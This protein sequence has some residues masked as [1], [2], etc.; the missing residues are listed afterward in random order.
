MDKSQ[1]EDEKISVTCLVIMFARG[2]KVIEMS[3]MALFSTF[4]LMTA[5]N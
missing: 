2:V 1:R 4:L 5:N 3:K